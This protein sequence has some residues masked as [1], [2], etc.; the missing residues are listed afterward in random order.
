LL[1]VLPWTFF[2]GALE[3][4]SMVLLEHAPLVRKSY[5]PRELLV[6]SVLFSRL[7]TLIIGIGVAG[8]LT[9]NSPRGSFFWPIPA[10]LALVAIAGGWGLFLAGVNVVL[11]DVAFLLRFALRFG[12]YACPI[13]YP[14]SLVPEGARGA[15]DF[16]PLVAI[17]W[18]FQQLANPNMP[19][20]PAVAMI[21]ATAAAIIS[22]VFGWWVFRRLRDPISDLL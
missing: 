12:F 5:F 16:N 18:C 4:S 9:I 17:L 15:Y 19:A 21:T 1:G 7:I 6:F 13:A 3:H 8:L 22:P 14:L 2:S 20:P 11:R 10:T